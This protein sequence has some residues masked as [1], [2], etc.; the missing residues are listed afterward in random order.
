RGRVSNESGRAAGIGGGGLSRYLL[1]GR[2]VAPHGVR[3]ALRV[4]S[5]ADPAESLVQHRHW[6]LRRLD[7]SEQ[8]IEVVQAVWDGRSVRANL[9][10]IA[11]RD[12]AEQLRG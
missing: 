6:R 4:Q 2:I 10:G 3:G 8:P 5:Y 1:L 7:G 11:D 12:A 9:A